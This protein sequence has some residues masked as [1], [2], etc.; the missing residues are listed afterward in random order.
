MQ[1][2]TE[3]G[4][5]W[6]Q[7]DCKKLTGHVVII[8][9]HCFVCQQELQSRSYQRNASKWIQYN[10][11]KYKAIT[12]AFN[13]TIGTK[14]PIT[15]ITQKNPDIKLKTVYL[16]NKQ[17]SLEAIDLIKMLLTDGLKHKSKRISKHE[18]VH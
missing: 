4:N 11:D 13:C 2:I 6:K 9:F 18:Y 17:M 3:L 14:T 5:N 10:N 7:V 1:I 12:V 8:I 15:L 16:P